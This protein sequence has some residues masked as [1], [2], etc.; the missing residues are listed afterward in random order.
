MIVDS[1]ALVE[2]FVAADPDGDLLKALSGE[3]Y[4]PHLLELEFCSVLR[5]LV[6]GGKIDESRAEAARRLYAE[7]WIQLQP[8]TGLTDRI[9]E[10][11]HNFT[12]YDAAYIVLAEALDLPLV[13]CDA[14]LAQKG[15]NHGARVLLFS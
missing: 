8:V 11:R 6:L 12:P 3:L 4:A 1:S 2:A 5:G 9:W 10:L 7:T 15:G 14:K 13:T